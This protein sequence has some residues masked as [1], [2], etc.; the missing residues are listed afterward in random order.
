[1]TFNLNKIWHEVRWCQ[2]TLPK[3][4]DGNTITDNVTVTSS[5]FSQND[6]TI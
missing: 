5:N 6:G 4:F 1:M 2:D 3:E